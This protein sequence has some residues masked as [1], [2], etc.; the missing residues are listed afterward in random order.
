MLHVTIM[1]SL[2]LITS[3]SIGQ[4]A[5]GN[6]MSFVLNGYGDHKVFKIHGVPGSFTFNMNWTGQAS[7]INMFLFSDNFIEASIRCETGIQERTYQLS[8]TLLYDA[9]Y[10]IFL[11]RSDA[12]A[13]SETINVGCN[14]LLDDLGMERGL[15]TSIHMVN[16]CKYY[17]SY[18]L[19]A[20]YA[21][22]FDEAL[23]NKVQRNLKLFL[24][25]A[26]GSTSTSGEI[27]I[28]LIDYSG[29]GKMGSS[30]SAEYGAYLE[31][32]QPTSGSEAHV[33]LG[34]DALNGFAENYVLLSNTELFPGTSFA[35]PNGQIPQ[36]IEGFNF[37]WIFLAMA[38]TALIIIAKQ[39]GRASITR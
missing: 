9:D 1:F 7:R 17:D 15:F 18:G 32:F 20:G 24:F 25:N 10:Y 33:L 8:T 22:H 5:R 23:I 16:A 11:F 4:E 31:T 36:E 39:R 26:G 6:N 12:E 28:R 21:L 34:G 38:L 35:T 2:F 19:Q 3:A 30:G 14:F 27:T 29:A 37:A 13:T